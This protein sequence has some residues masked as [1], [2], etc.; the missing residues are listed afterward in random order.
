MLSGYW[1]TAVFMALLMLPLAPL[2]EVF[3]P[4]SEEFEA[5][6][7]ES[8]AW[9]GDDFWGQFRHNPT[10]N[11]SMPAHSSDGGPNGGPV[12]NVTSLMTIDNPTMNWQH[13]ADSHYGADGFG[14]VIADFANSITAP[15]AAAERCGD[16]ISFA[17]MVHSQNSGGQ[18]NSIL[19]IIDGGSGKVAW[20]VDLGSTKPV[21]AAP[22]VVDVDGDGLLEIMVAY[23]SDAA[24]NLD[25]YSP[26][27]SCSESGW[28]SSG[29]SSELL[30]SWS[31]SEM[32]L[33]TDSP[34]WAIQQSDHLVSTQL[35][36][37]DIQM[38]GSAYAILALIDQNT[39][40][41]TIKAIQLATTGPPEPTWSVA[42]DRGTHVSDPTW[43]AMDELNSA[44]LLTTI[45]GNNGNMWVWRIDGESGS[46][47]WERVTLS[48]TQTDADPVHLR[49]PGPI[50]TQLDNDDAPE[51]IFTIPS[52]QNGRSSGNG[53][54]FVAWDLTSTDE[55]WRFRAYN[56]YADA[57][58]IA[59]DD[60]GDGIH[61]KV[62]WV[63]WYSTSS[64]TF[65]RQGLA[66]CHDVSGEPSELFRHTMDSSSGND[67]DEIA[68][69]APLSVD[70]NGEG[71]NEL[72]VAFGRRLYAFDVA[73][74]TSASVNSD[75]S[76]PLILPHRTWSAPA[77]GDLDGDGALDL[78]IG[79]TLVSRTI[80]DAAPTSDSRGIRFNPEQPNPGQTVTISA[81]FSNIGTAAFEGGFDAVLYLGGQEIGRHR[82][83]D[84]EP[85]APSGDGGP[86]SFSVSIVATRG[87]HEAKLVLDPLGNHSQARIDND[88][89][90]ATLEVLDPHVVEISPPISLTR[91][92]PG[93]SADLIPS[94]TAIGR[95]TAT[96][97]MSVDEYLPE[98]WTLVD[99]TSGGSQMVELI[100]GVIWNPV[101]RISVPDNAEGSESGYVVIR[102]S[103]DENSSISFN[104]TI[105]IEVLRTQGLS[106]QGPDGL[107]LSHGSGRIGHDASA[108]FLIEN[109]GNAYETSSSITWDLNGWQKQPRIYDSNG[110]EVNLIELQP[111]ESREFIAKVEVPTDSVSL[112]DWVSNNLEI[113][114][115]SNEQTLCRDIDFHFTANGV[116]LNPPHIREEPQIGKSWEIEVSKPNGN[117]LSWDFGAA[118][119]LKDGWIWN[120]EGDLQFSAGILSTIAGPSPATGWLNLSIPST[121]P[122]DIHIANISAIEA[123]NHDLNLSLHV[124]QVHRSDISLSQPI[125]E[126]WMVNVSSGEN[127][128]GD[129]LILRLENP[130]NGLDSFLLEGHVILDANH[131]SDPGVSF[132]IPNPVRNLSAGAVV[133]VPV[134][135]S[136]PPEI[137]A[138]VPLQLRFSLTSLI[139]PSVS[140]NVD[141]MIQA[142]PDHRWQLELTGAE[143]R[144][145]SPGE[146]ISFQF[147]ASNVGNSLDHLEL[148]P[149]L[150]LQ[151]VG[152]DDSVWQFSGSSLNDIETGDSG[153]VW[154]NSTIP[155]DTWNG[156]VAMVNI[157]LVSEEVLVSTYTIWIEVSHKTGW[158]FNLSNTN[159]EV[160]PEGGTISVV[161]EQRGNLPTSP[162]FSLVMPEWNLSYPSNAEIVS[163]GSQTTLDIDVT[164]PADGLAGQVS[165]LIIRAR[166]SDG[167][168]LGQVTIPLRIGAVHE[169]EMQA[170]DIWK[171]TLDGG[172]PLVWFENTGNALSNIQVELEGLPSGWSTT[173][174]TSIIIAPGQMSGLE[175]DLNPADDWDGTNVLIS[176]KVT[177]DGG[178]EIERDISVQLANSSWRGS[179]LLYGLS[180]DEVEI[181]TYG[182]VNSLKLSNPS[183]NIRKEGEGWWLTLPENNLDTVAEI[184]TTQGEETLPLRIETIAKNPRGV[185][186]TINS[187]VAETL[188][189]VNHNDSATLASC[190]VANGS[191]SLKAT[192]IL[193]TDNGEIVQSQII[194][195]PAGTE[196]TFNL[197]SQ[198]WEGEA[199][200]LILEIRAID[201]HGRLLSSDSKPIVIR[202][203]GWNIG[204]A[205][206]EERSNGGLRIGVLRSGE[207]VLQGVDCRLSLSANEWSG[208]WTLDVVSSDFAPIIDLQRPMVS[209]GE[210]VDV[211]VFCES[212]FDIDDIPSDD[213][214]SIVL[215]TQEL[216]EEIESG[217]LWGSGVA[218]LTLFALWW[219][220]LL[221]PKQQATALAP[222]RKKKKSTSTGRVENVEDDELSDESL[223]LDIGDEDVQRIS[224]VEI[225]EEGADGSE[226]ETTE[227]S[228]LGS[229]IKERIKQ[230]RASARDQVEAAD[231]ADDLDRRIDELFSRRR[232]DS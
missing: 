97:S 198:G 165:L 99:T 46:L 13:L 140:D 60:D 4:D 51:V 141:I 123:A 194:S 41:P 27:L 216:A 53:A 195:A 204:I 166:E 178:I 36:I 171:V 75:W 122:P 120:A 25:V 94:I 49:V 202:K 172:V 86:V 211:R 125:P 183:I 55:L 113:C 90:I 138:R 110:A 146:F 89:A 104:S 29:H 128:E 15:A 131:T 112:G 106:I 228:G 164:P 101:L 3:A 197:S 115:G 96:W 1:R 133:H 74:G 33:G 182:D 88:I 190:S 87:I 50:V 213:S 10:R 32:R 37:A 35:L 145:A 143:Q 137:P 73:T 38:D 47:D 78:L 159:L 39:G 95:K 24:A 116:S 66:G 105:P 175:I 154:V 217:M 199:G 229:D 155:Q 81:Q 23:D 67:N 130:G 98:G 180:G 70:I 109:L 114:I 100:P 163:P 167:N 119:L 56:G 34:H 209:D 14:T 152:G 156:T 222:E 200:N 118:G 84:L 162:W 85:V 226:I 223:H 71:D 205:Y 212:P 108:W 127:D 82:S 9:Y 220:G 231:D 135:I 186:C 134:N 58:P 19:S 8:S 30:W 65:E 139:L 227:N 158:G 11:S 150:N 221:I 7:R 136:L 142:R 161:V 22:A 2:T 57:A 207:S 76:N 43:V 184:S 80:A 45:D 169:L 52:D 124:L 44:I 5:Q 79:D 21:K 147:N 144:L 83:T 173:G 42:L 149:Q 102:M 107:P 6:G 206:V 196:P 111:G 16:G 28:D 93:E 117:D 203:T 132:L 201:S 63:T 40:N 31:D 230:L 72:V 225:E 153:L 174:T 189:S 191:N 77:A 148:Q 193:I 208:T 91:I 181:K 179:P 92:L 64:L 224:L 17:V 219:A 54:T 232:K 168:G 192:L 218:I 187:G 69:C 18:G 160:S 62:C 20:K 103:L 177:A 26:R 215:S 151:R 170:E 129:R 59:I 188:G 48:G 126:P 61:E 68:A 121:A 214:D 176:I 157:S 185:S 12:E 210:K